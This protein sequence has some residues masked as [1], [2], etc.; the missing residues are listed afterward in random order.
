MQEKKERR[1]VAPLGVI[2]M[3]GCQEMGDKI[4]RHLLK[5]RESERPEKNHLRGFY[6]EEKDSFLVGTHFARFS[7]GEG[8]GMLSETVRGYDLYILTDIGAYAS[9]YR[10][11][12]RDVMMSPDMHYADLKRIISAASGKASRIHVVM[13]FLYGAY[14][15]R[16]VLQE[17]LDCAVM[18][19]ELSDL[20]VSNFITFDAHEL[21]MSNANPLL[22]M[23]NFMPTFQILKA[24][25]KT[26][27]DLI[28]DKDHLMVVAPSTEAVRRNIYY[29]SG[30]HVNLGMF[31]KAK[32]T[33]QPVGKDALSDY[34]YLGESVEGK[35][36]FIADDLIMSGENLTEVAHC[37]KCSGARRVMIGVTYA[38]FTEGLERYDMAYEKHD[39]DHV[40]AT[41]LT[42]TPQELLD[43]PWFSRA[44]LSKYLASI[45]STLNYDQTL[46]GL[47]NP[48]QRI[49][50][51]ITKHGIKQEKR[52]IAE[53]AKKE[54]LPGTNGL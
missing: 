34:R 48:W 22:A 29:A 4:N 21:C 49:E 32:G 41:N 46:S 6:G 54:A 18:L 1:P 26:Y 16:N 8:K 50:K 27:P 9:T 5:W 31:Y 35:D 10:M 17:S 45:I 40:F 24:L 44:D 12:D 38:F 33:G 7:T 47:L 30:L 52:R 36:V 51:L 15:Y 28:I 3:S 37:L 13:P 20:G 25:C 2:A 19:Q 14:T 53:E 23:E 39:L 42:Y 11:Y 43:R